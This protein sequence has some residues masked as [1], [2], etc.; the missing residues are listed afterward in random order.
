MENFA[1]K[2]TT[3]AKFWYKEL[4]EKKTRNFPIK[5]NI[6]LDTID[7]GYT[8]IV[9]RLKFAVIKLGVFFLPSPL[10]SER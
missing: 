1:N 2:N 4:V 6:L 3:L 9:E 5:T 10:G 7:S 8:R